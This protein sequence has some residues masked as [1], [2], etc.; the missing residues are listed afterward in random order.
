MPTT[1]NLKNIPDV[2]CDRLKR[3]AELHRRCPSSDAIACLDAVLAP[4]RVLPADLLLRARM[5]RADL[6]LKVRKIKD[7]DADKRQGRS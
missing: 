1:L 4:R 6:Q 3:S 5:L 2:V 7:I